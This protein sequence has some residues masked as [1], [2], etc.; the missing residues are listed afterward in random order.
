MEELALDLKPIPEHENSVDIMY[1]DVPDDSFYCPFCGTETI[2]YI[3]NKLEYNVCD[4]LI[5][6]CAEGATLMVSDVF[7]RHL[8]ELVPT[9]THERACETGNIP[10]PDVDGSIVNV[11]TNSFCG[12]VPNSLTI[13]TFNTGN[14]EEVTVSYAPVVVG[15]ASPNP[16]LSA[17]KAM[18]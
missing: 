6:A 9:V 4:H 5:C 15:A 2:S 8:Q 3:N 16:K 7:L 1:E 18:H 14:G 10:W 11:S 17:P 12:I 13:H